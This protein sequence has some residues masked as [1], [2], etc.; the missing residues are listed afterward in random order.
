MRRV[1]VFLLMFLPLVLVQAQGAPVPDDPACGDGG[2]EGERHG[3]LLCVQ[4][5]MSPRMGGWGW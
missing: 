4:T 5:A 2:D 3:R 1:P